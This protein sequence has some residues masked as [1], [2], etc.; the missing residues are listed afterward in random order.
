[1]PFVSLITLTV[2]LTSTIPSSGYGVSRSPELARAAAVSFIARLQTKDVAGAVAL[3]DAP[4]I[5]HE[6]KT[7]GSMAE[8]KQYFETMMASVPPDQQPTSVIDVK[9]YAETRDETAEEVLAVRD[10]VLKDGG[11][12]VFVG[13][14]G[15]L[16]G[17]LLIRV[18]DKVAKVVGIG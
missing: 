11:Y 1:M 17:V 13:R 15:R 4:F 7:L 6:Q 5:T 14:G 2:T 10:P 3:C 12:I 9:T 18:K 8:V 16:G